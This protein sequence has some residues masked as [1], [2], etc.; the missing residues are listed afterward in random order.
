[1]GCGIWL[2]WGRWRKCLS[3][4]RSWCAPL[5]PLVARPLHQEST[6]CGEHSCAA[7]VSDQQQQGPGIGRVVQ[8]IRASVSRQGVSRVAGSRRF[9]PVVS[10][11]HQ[12]STTCERPTAR[13]FRLQAGH[14]MCIVM[15][16]TAHIVARGWVRCRIIVS[17]HSL[18]GSQ[19]Q[20]SL[21]YIPCT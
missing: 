12:Y 8:S 15:A 19:T 2:T 4:R 13:A 16:I 1:M 21:N 11:L 17:L 9:T 6:T 18:Q 5:G 3:G 7:H 10:A 20:C 14:T